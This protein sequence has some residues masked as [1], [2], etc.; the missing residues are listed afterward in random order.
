MPLLATPLFLFP[1]HVGLNN[2]NFTH[3]ATRKFRY[4]IFGLHTDQNV[5][6]TLVLIMSFGNLTAVLLLVIAT[7]FGAENDSNLSTP[8]LKGIV[9]VTCNLTECGK[10]PLPDRPLGKNL[11]HLQLQLKRGGELLRTSLSI[12]QKTFK[13]AFDNPKKEKWLNFQCVWKNGN[14]DVCQMEVF[15]DLHALPLPAQNLSISVSNM[16][17]LTEVSKT[18]EVKFDAKFRGQNGSA[19]SH[20]VTAH[21]YNPL[22]KS[23][24]VKAK[25]IIMRSETKVCINQDEQVFCNGLFKYYV[26]MEGI[27]TAIITSKN[28]FGICSSSEFCKVISFFDIYGPVEQFKGWSKVTPSNLQLEISWIVPKGLKNVVTKITFSIRYCNGKCNYQN[29]TKSVL[30]IP[31]EG[32]MKAKITKNVDYDSVYKVSIC[33]LIEGGWN[34]SVSP[35]MKAVDVNTPKK[36]PINALK[37]FKCDGQNGMSVVWRNVH[38]DYYLMKIEESQRTDRYVKVFA[39]QCKV[40]VCSFHMPRPS[41][42]NGFRITVSSCSKYGC[43]N[44]STSYCYFQPQQNSGKLTGQSDNRMVFMISLPFAV[45]FVAL[46]LSIIAFKICKCATSQSFSDDTVVVVGPRAQEYD[47]I[48]EAS[49]DEGDYIIT[50]N[51]LV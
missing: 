27:F 3:N 37:I 21:K 20:Y 28:Q 18:I 39:N 40:E 9:F 48:S 36:R 23:C 17:N 11:T 43:D 31:I 26:F 30:D 2:N 12:Q 44:S 45:A 4:Q 8:C 1:N 24:P 25:D 5:K 51:E 16:N 33:Y 15:T 38:E 35:W 42:T 46:I 29:V 10:G 7:S 6:A 22:T 13:I 32:L 41:V 14:E 47:N 50:L 19:G 49:S 34:P